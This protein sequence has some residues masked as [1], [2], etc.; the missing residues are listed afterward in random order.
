[1]KKLAKIFSR[2]FL[3]DAVCLGAFVWS[4]TFTPYGGYACATPTLSETD[5]VTRTIDMHP[6]RVP[7]RVQNS[8]EDLRIGMLLHELIH[9]FLSELPCTYCPTAP[10]NLGSR[11]NG[12]GRAW[13]LLARAIEKEAPRILGLSGETCLGRLDA[14]TTFWMG[15]GLPDDAGSHDLERYGF[16]SSAGVPR[17]R[18]S[19]DAGARGTSV[20]GAGDGTEERAAWWRSFLP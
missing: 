5:Q 15:D 20:D 17:R 13:L 9:A 16:W 18:R 19:L 6:T 12:H 3:L 14:L 1:M 10:E 8:M 11:K 7:L 2:I 4:T